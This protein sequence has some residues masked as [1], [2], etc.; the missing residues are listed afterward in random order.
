MGNKKVAELKKQITQCETNKRYSFSVQL[1]NLEKKLTNTDSSDE[2]IE[3]SKKITSSIAVVAARREKIPPLNFPEQLPVSQRQ[4][5]IVE[6]I[7]KHPVVIVAGE[8]G[9]GKTTQIPKMCL[10]AGL[11]IS[12]L[13]GHT[14]PRRLA[15]RTVAQRIADELQSPLGDLVGYK[16]RFQDKLSEHTRIKLLTDGMLLAEVGTDRFLSRYDVIIIDEAHERSLNIDFLLGYL[17]RLLV[18]RRDLKVIITS[19]TIDHWR[20]SEFF[21]GAPVIEVT[22]RT[23]PVSIEY[24]PVEN[25]VVSDS[26]DSTTT[27]AEPIQDDEWELEVHILKAIQRID[28]IERAGLNKGRPRDILVFLA[29]E[30]DIRQVADFLRKQGPKQLEILPLYSRLSNAEQNKVFQVHGQRRIVL[31]TNVAETSITVPNIG[32]V[33][34]PGRARISRYNYRTKVQRLPIESISQASANQRA[35]RCGRVAEGVCI[36]LYS[37]E[38]FLGRPEFTEPEILRTNLASVILQMRGQNL[39]QPE[40][41]PFIEAPDPRSLNDGYRLLQ[42]LG[43]IDSQKQVTAIGKALLKFPVDPRL[44]RMLIA[45]KDFQCLKELLIIISG[46]AVPEPWLR[47]HGQRAAADESLKSFQRERS[48]FLTFFE[49]WCQIETNKANLSNKLYRKWLV[50]KYLSYLRVREWQDIYR[51]LKQTCLEMGWAENKEAASY[52]EIHKAILVGLLDNVAIKEDRK[53]YKAARNRVFHIFPGSALKPGDGKW[54]VAA[55]IIETNR[56]Y[57]RLIAQIEPQ[58]I[59]TLAKHLLKRVYN[60]PHWEKK[61][62]CTVAYEQT[63]L[64]GLVVNPH[65]RVNYSTI[66]PVKSREIFIRHALVYGD[67]DTRAPYAAHNKKLVDE[68]EYLEQKTRRR[69]ILIDELSLY[70]W[71]DK[72]IPADIVNGRSFEAW[73]KKAEETDPEILFMKESDLIQNETSG[74]TEY[75]YPDEVIIK[76]GSLKIDY[77]FE[78]GKTRDGLNIEV[79]IMLLNQLDVKKLEWLVPGLEREK[80]IALIKS[81]PKTLRKQFVPVPDF[82][83]AFLATNPNR[84]QSLKLQLTTFLK[85]QKSVNIELDSWDESSLP[86]YLQ[87]HLRV[88]NAKGKV[89]AEGRDLEAVIQQCQ[90]DFKAA[91]QTIAANTISGQVHRTWDFG[92]LDDVQEMQENGLVVRVFPALVDCSDGV[93]LQLFESHYRAQNSTSMGLLRLF[94]LAQPQLVRYVKKHYELPKKT[95]LYYSAFGTGPELTDGFVERVFYQAFVFDDLEIRTEQQFNRR[96]Q[97]GKAEL[98]DSALFIQRLLEE[99]LNGYHEVASLISI[100]SS[101]GT[102]E[103][104]QDIQTQLESLFPRHW[105]K[106][107]PLSRLV[108]YPRYLKALVIRWQ[109]LQGK[110]DRDK[111]LID[112]LKQLWERYQRQQTKLKEMDSTDKYLEEWRWA[113]EEYRISLFAQGMKTLYP[114][115]AKRLEKLWQK[116]DT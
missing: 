11:G 69:D 63:S 35:G 3:L 18:Q 94:L 58:W 24:L 70:D 52:E 91:I 106:S 79:P 77:Q 56:I 116:V 54:V 72:K 89:I 8:T 25:S 10:A 93:T 16:I 64:F 65:K 95:Q 13:I 53:V 112:E 39:G 12:G 28:E 9:S 49:T 114:I 2:I 46:M 31:S 99:I 87:A 82:A 43:A 14:Q 104:R 100:D 61:S 32:Y 27:E 98:A 103:T 109:R 45:A 110:V 36:R 50:S 83:D 4:D 22:G 90:T 19:A 30:R 108:Q 107:I 6:L 41:F 59:E 33:I 17:K 76:G 113:L 20:F 96:M 85:A 105:L 102:L 48:D 55:E 75:H 71:F 42:E 115:S 21:N 37:E 29:G 66:D 7:K 26:M 34:D 62:A 51:Q 1:K 15:A 44:G 47:P 73:R 5:E 57:G 38:D 111:I 68:L 92:K 78:P 84:D 80:C 23:Y 97:Q 67:Y 74:D 40:R 86:L 60:E 101:P 88:L 81:L